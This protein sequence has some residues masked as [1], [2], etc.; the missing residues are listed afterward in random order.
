M[1]LVLVLLLLG[2]LLPALGRAGQD[3]PVQRMLV[4]GVDGMDPRLLRRFMAE[5]LMPNYSRLARRGGFMELG[6]SVPPQSPVAWSNFITGM[7]P[8]GHGIFDFLG[9]DRETMF[10]YQSITRV[11]RAERE[12]I[13]L[14]RWR[15]PLDS[16]ETLQLRDGV[17][18]WDLLEKAGVSTTMFRVPANYPPTETG[19]RALSGMG[20]PDLRGTPG[21]FTF[22]TDDPGFE[23]GSVSGGI[24]RRVRR[25]G[26]R[27][28]TDLEGPPNGFLEGAPRARSDFVVYVDP[29]H[30][31][32]EI[33][34]GDQRVLL[35]VGE[36]SEWVQLDFEMI[37]HLFSVAGMS[38]FYLKQLSPH[39]M[40]YASPVNIDPAEPAQ[41]IST[42]E[43]Y[44]PEL[45]AAAGRFYTQEMPEDTK[46]LSAHT[47]TPSEFVAQSEL[48]MDERRRLFRYELKRF[49][50]REDRQLLFFYF[51]SIDLRSHMLWRQMDASH[52]YHEPGTPPD[53]AAAL[54][55]VYVELDEILGWALE[56][57]DDD[58]TLIVMSD[59]GFAPFRRQANLNTWLERNGYLVL[60][61]PARRASYEWLSGLDWSRTRAFA[62]GLNSLY[63]NVRG[64]ERYGIVP[65]EEREAL[66]R[67]IAERLRRWKDPENGELVVTQPALREE[68]YHG[69]H[70]S[71]APDILVGYARGYRAS[72]ATTSGK[73]PARLL[74]D[75]LREWS[76]DH[77][78]DSRT[79]PGILLSNR[80]LH[81]AEADLKDLPVT[82]LTTFGVEVPES[83]KGSSIF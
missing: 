20:T 50:G 47:L 24:I 19:G 2:Q 62:I 3:P 31:V 43:G 44:A 38:R 23:D 46:A 64:R 5:G 26:N 29:E 6:T 32:A 73:I 25:V 60:K 80:A 39:F 83:M 14:G 11:E 82:I 78:M 35:A 28:D 71:E 58:T 70:V 8:G 51:P 15:I 56:A 1:R 79:V 67:E 41:K 65:P 57:V 53:L 30:P 7:D 63:L 59:H 61:D 69:E 9:L 76:G 74:E 33:R 36:W 48:V 42:P 13:Q 34:A 72:W 49:R 77:C 66:A 40:L 55:D 52:P 17:A 4:L 16:D 75:N 37:P 81:V 54:R 22:F 10:P 21:T 12:P 45:A 18:F 27:V 68:V